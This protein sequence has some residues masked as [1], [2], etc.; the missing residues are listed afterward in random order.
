MFDNLVSLDNISFILVFL[1]GVISFFS[2]C[3]IP[4]IPLYMSYLAGNAKQVNE[5]G[6]IYYKRSKVFLQ[7]MFF[8]LGITT[9]FFV[10]GISFTALGSFLQRHTTLFTRIAGII[11]IILGLVQVGF[12]DIKFLNKERRVKGNFLNREMG[13][14]ALCNGTCI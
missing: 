1:E 11:I 3:V 7:T 6:S 14:L 12:I 9:V 8:V 4:L 10:L 2:P 5:D 13:P